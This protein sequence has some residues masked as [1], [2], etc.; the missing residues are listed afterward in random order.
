MWLQ[1][2]RFDHLKAFT[3]DPHTMRKGQKSSKAGQR[4][5]LRIIFWQSLPLLLLCFVYTIECK[6]IGVIGAAAGGGGGGKTFFFAK[7]IRIRN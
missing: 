6:G 3:L 7:T 1:G 2:D 4:L 5:R